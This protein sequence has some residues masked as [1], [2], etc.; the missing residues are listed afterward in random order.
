MGSEMCIRDR[1]SSLF[2][3]KNE[4]NMMTNGADSNIC[5]LMLIISNEKDESKKESL[6]KM[7]LS[8]IRKY[9]VGNEKYTQLL[10]D[11]LERLP[12]SKWN[13]L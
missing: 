11:C 4:D 8:D 5:S 6:K 9:T 1:L 2:P 7:E 10:L 12:G 3:Y 13:V